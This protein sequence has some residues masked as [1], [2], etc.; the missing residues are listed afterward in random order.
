LLV[1]TAFVEPGSALHRSAEALNEHLQGANAFYV[2]LETNYDGAFKE[3]ANL[4]QIATLQRWLEAQPEIGG[5]TSLVDYLKLINRGMH[6]GDPA[7]FA[8]P[9]TKSLVTQLLFFG[10]ND[11][12]EGFVDTRYQ[13]AGIQVRSTVGESA[14]MQ[15]LLERIEERAGLLS[16]EISARVTGNTVLLTRTIDDIVRGQAA[17]L[18]FAFAMILLVLSVLFTSL[19]VGLLALVPNALPVLFYF[20]LL[21]LA[22]VT[23]NSTTGLVAC[24]VLGIAVDDTIH[25]L[26]R[27]NEAA[28]R[29]ADE[30]QGVSDALRAVGRP[31]TTTTVALCA[32]FLVLTTS[33]FE[34]QVQFGAL[35]AVTLAFAWLVDLTFTP[36]L[37]TRMHIVNLFDVLTLDLGQDPHR[38]IPLF[39]G[40]RKTQARITALMASIVEFPAGHRLFSEG[41]PGSDMYVVIEGSLDVSVATETGTV[42]LATLRR[43]DDA[44]AEH[45][46]VEQPTSSPRRTSGCCA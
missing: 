29:R 10:G 9:E 3:P 5:T 11:E 27:F 17:S 1:S 38:S 12:L 40:L 23:L 44:A 31:V 4:R 43:G 16:E 46:Q 14:E 45:P 2:V 13:T 24:L 15:K 37:A 7:H 18:V 36:A 41:E 21:G 35:A 20:G 28:K 25:F 32:G 30:S 6:G 22:G 8:I 19:R 34:N 39:R 42:H 33:H 26:A